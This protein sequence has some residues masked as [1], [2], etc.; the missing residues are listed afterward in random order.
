MIEQLI[1]RVF[2]NSLIRFQRPLILVLMV[3]SA[4]ACVGLT[5]WGAHW[6]TTLYLKTQPWFVDPVPW[7]QLVA[8]PVLLVIA[9]LLIAWLSAR[10]ARK[11]LRQIRGDGLQFLDEQH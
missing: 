3:P 5:I 10:M 9:P 4:L 7:V 6:T 1:A 8:A 2:T 11:A